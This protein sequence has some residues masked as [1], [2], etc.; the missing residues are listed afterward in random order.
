MPVSE[1]LVEHIRELL[2]RLYDYPFLQEHPLGLALEA[3]E[4]L[5]AQQRMRALRTLILNGIEQMNPSPDE[6]LRSPRARLYNVLNL[7]YVEGLMVQEVAAELAISERQV[8]RDLRRAERDLAVLLAPRLGEAAGSQA[9]TPAEPH[10]DPIAQEAERLSGERLE[11]DVAEL[12][13]GAISAVTQ[14]AEDADVTVVVPRGPLE[15]TLYT[16]RQI[17][18]QAL[19]SLLSH[20]VKRARRGS[21]VR[22]ETGLC[23]GVLRIDV[24]YVVQAADPATD[25]CPQT[26]HRLMQSLGGVCEVQSVSDRS[27][28]LRLTLNAST[29]PAVLVIDDHAGLIELFTRY[30]EGEPYRITGAANG[31]EG[32]AVAERIQPTAII[33]DVMMPE[34]D[35]WEVLQRLQTL[36]TTRTIPVI[37]C[38]V[39]NDP[40]LALSLGAEAF[41]AKPVSR[42]DLLAALATVI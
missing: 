18:R 19:L 1:R 15:R 5:A 40:E 6:P 36:E 12:L 26:A 37:I 27:V 39:L 4:P 31:A 22:V 9:E 20:A 28:M 41:L 42:A 3:G 24:S 7:H 2:A 34:Q 29:C 33:L 10:V 14:L 25:Q 21:P 17:L 11:F 32:I 35:G 23:E 38:S 13:Q 8:Y 30:L 16:N